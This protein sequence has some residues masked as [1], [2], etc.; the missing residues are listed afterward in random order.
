LAPQ[1]IPPRVNQIDPDGKSGM[2]EIGVYR[3]GPTGAAAFGSTDDGDRAGTKKIFYG[4]EQD[5]A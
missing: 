4:T 1:R 2:L 5:W 3:A